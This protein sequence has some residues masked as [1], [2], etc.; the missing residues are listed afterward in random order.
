M[1]GQNTS[2]PLPHSIWK[3]IVEDRYVDFAKLFASMDPG[4][5]PNDDLK[6]FGGGYALVKKDYLSA[7]WAIHT[8]SDWIRVFT[9]W[10]SGVTIL[11][12]HR[13]DELSEYRHRVDNIFCAA[14]DD[15]LAAIDFD[16]EV[17][18]HYEKCPFH[19]DDYNALQ[20]PLLAQMFHARSH[21]L[22]RGP[23]T[24]AGSSSAPSKRASVICH[25]W[26][27]GSCAD[28][29]VNRRKHGTCSECGNQHCALDSEPC[30]NLL[31]SRRTKNTSSGI[32][33]D[34]T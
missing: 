7:K 24:Q 34:H 25:N 6:D 18:Q 8:E 30:F 27:F 31:Q 21:G 1:R 17:R 29:C 20:A 5:D 14:H 19:M 23:D 22:K 33:G 9:A 4:Y 3:L 2:W 32:S 16:A 12:P 28:P 15:P 13:K 26:N 10:E 11:Y